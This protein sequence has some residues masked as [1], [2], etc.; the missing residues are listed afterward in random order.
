MLIL[1]SLYQAGVAH[2]MTEMGAEPDSILDN[3]G[4]DPENLE[5]VRD[6]Q[7]RLEQLQEETDA[8]APPEM[9]EEYTGEY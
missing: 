7:A 8:L 1:F 4:V 9:D 5:F 6:N 2:A 3:T